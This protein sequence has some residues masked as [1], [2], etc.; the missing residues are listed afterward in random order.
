ME[1]PIMTDIR[2]WVAKTFGMELNITTF[3]RIVRDT[4]PCMVANIDAD[5]TNNRCNLYK[6]R[7]PE[8]DKKL[9]EWAVAANEK[10]ACITGSVIMAKAKKLAHEMN[11]TNVGNVS[12]G[13]L[14]GFQRRHNVKMYRLHGESASVPPDVIEKG[15]EMLQMETL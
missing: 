1:R 11:L 13:W 5:A 6:P 9:A 3:R 10:Q 4:R 7:H 8:L 2:K 12:R 15:R 14:Y